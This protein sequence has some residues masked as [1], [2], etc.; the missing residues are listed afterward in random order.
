M[1]P[2]FA[3]HWTRIYQ[4]DALAVLP[5]LPANSVHVCVTSPPY[6]GLRDYGTAT[7]AGGDPACT[8]DVRHWDGPKQTQG[9]QSGHA[10]KADRLSRDHCRCG[11]VRHDPGIGNETVPDCEGYRKGTLGEMQLRDDLTEAERRYVIE[12]LLK[13]GVL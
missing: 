1:E 10:A 9:A 4:G 5:L 3:D 7:W 6:W 8:H 13:Y 12:E 2:F 11:A